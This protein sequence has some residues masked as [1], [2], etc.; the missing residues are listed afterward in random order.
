MNRE[1][2]GQ[3]RKALIASTFR[4]TFHPFHQKH[5]R[6]DPEQP[7]D[8]IES[9]VNERAFV[10]KLCHSESCRDDRIDD[11]QQDEQKRA[12]QFFQPYWH[13]STF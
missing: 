5:C 9:K 6:Q 2:E 7:S 1:V 3:R 10:G 13:S 4:L 11:D 12:D 8:K